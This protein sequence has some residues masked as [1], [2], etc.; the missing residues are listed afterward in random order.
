MSKNTERSLIVLFVI[1]SSPI[2]TIPV[3]MGLATLALNVTDGWLL[4]MNPVI[5]LIQALS[6]GDL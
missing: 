5:D 3:V 1:L 6:G 4:I 2:W